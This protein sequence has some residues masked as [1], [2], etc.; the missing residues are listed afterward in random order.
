MSESKV[1]SLIK[2]SSYNID[3]RLLCKFQR[4]FR[5]QSHLKKTHLEKLELFDKLQ[6]LLIFFGWLGKFSDTN[7]YLK[8]VF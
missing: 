6:F 7:E 2:L 3:S 8:K 5:P 1:Q 4:M